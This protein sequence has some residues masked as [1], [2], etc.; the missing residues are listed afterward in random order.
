MKPELEK[1]R[2]PN[3]YCLLIDRGS[4]RIKWIGAVWHAMSGRWDL[5]VTSFG[6]GGLEDLEHALSGGQIM[7]PEEVLYCCVGSDERSAELERAL[8]AH[9]SAKAVRMRSQANCC[10]VANGYREPEQL[11]ADRWMAIV[12]AVAQY[13]APALVM[14]LGTATTIDMVDP[15]G[16]HLGGMILPGPGTMLR[17]LGM[18]TELE[19]DGAEG[20]D[21]RGRSGEPQAN[22]SSAIHGGIVSAQNGALSEALRWF[23]DHLGDM[24]DTQVQVIVTGGAAGAILKQSVYQL[25]HDPLLVFRGMLSSRFG[26]GET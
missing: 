22:T 18:Q 25:T 1:P 19:T 26:F 16:R 23:D 21:A 9:C 6:E 8:A 17:A 14:D 2:P 13:N 3:R 20:F 4:S 5:D 11:G 24:G 15:K 10:G 12:G 7:P